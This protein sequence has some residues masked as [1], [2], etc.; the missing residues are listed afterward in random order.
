M[1]LFKVNIKEFEYTTARTPN[2]ND[3]YNR[4]NIFY[5]K[6]YIDSSN[7]KDFMGGFYRLTHKNCFINLSKPYHNYIKDSF[8]HL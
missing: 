6:N 3:Y 8:F 5:L 1:R 7:Y 4:K 2:L